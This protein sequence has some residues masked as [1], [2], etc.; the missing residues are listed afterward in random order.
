MARSPSC[1]DNILKHCNEALERATDEGRVRKNPW[2]RLERPGQHSGVTEYIS[3][4]TIAQVIKK[5]DN[6][7]HIRV[8]SLARFAGLRISS[9]L[10]NQKWGHV[11]LNEDPRVL[12]HSPKT[13]RYA[14]GD[15]RICPL[16]FGLDTLLAHESEGPHVIQQPELWKYKGNANAKWLSDVLKSAKVPQR[17][18]LWT[19]LR[20]SAEADMRDL[21]GVDPEQVSLWIGHDIKTYRKHYRN[22]STEARRCARKASRSRT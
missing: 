6:V 2:K 22:P 20:E 16:L 3:R 4:A 10:I 1:V 19:S 8:L 21:P 5:L 13:A 12:I 17:R 11:T 18:G 14:G 7:A 15:S 9:E